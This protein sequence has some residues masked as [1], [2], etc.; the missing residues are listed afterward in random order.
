MQ[1]LKTILSSCGEYFPIS[2]VVADF[3]LDEQPLNFDY[4]YPQTTK[5]NASFNGVY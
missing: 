1:D 5:G 4:R 3:T 2:F